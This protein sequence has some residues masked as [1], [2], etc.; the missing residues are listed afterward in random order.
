MAMSSNKV[1]VWT[2]TGLFLVPSLLR[3]G[4]PE[5]QKIDQL[6]KR[7][8]EL[9]QELQSLRQDLTVETQSRR[10]QTLQLEE[11]QTRV[12]TLDESRLASAFNPFS[13]FRFGGYGEIHANFREDS[14]ADILDFHRLVLYIGYDFADWITFHSEWE[15]EHAYVSSGSGGEFLIEQAYVDFLL[16]EP[17]NLRV[18]RFLT[19]LGITNQRHEPPFF[20]GVERPAFDQ[21]II[22]TTWSSDGV[23]FFGRLHPSLTYEAYVAGG[24]DGSRFTETS[25]LRNGRIKERASLSDL[26]CMA[27]L[28]WRPFQQTGQDLRLGFSGYMGGLDNGNNGNNPGIDADIRIAS[29]DFEYSIGKWDFR[30]ALA[31]IDL[32]KPEQL[33]GSGQN[34][35]EE[36]FGWYLEAGY[37]FWPDEWKKGKLAQSDAVAFIR[38]DDFDTQYRMPSGVAGNPAADRKEWT[39]GVNF[40]PTSNFVVKADYQVTEDAAPGDPGNRWNLGLGWAF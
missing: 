26:A 8:A 5:Q 28:D 14:D 6:E 21:F 20:N 15:L 25:G 36:M 1:I 38:Y 23:G 9:S 29:A 13:N 31:H 39:L 35:A 2:L 12:E 27:R 30:G 17:L 18:G 10:Q 16:S 22:P 4:T 32:D 40:Y 37:H 19:P 7:I 33:G 34:I 11:M 24:L 3:G